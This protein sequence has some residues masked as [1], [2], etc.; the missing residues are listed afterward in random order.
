M[1]IRTWVLSLFPAKGSEESKQ[2]LASS[3]H[4]LE[5]RAAGAKMG[6]VVPRLALSLGAPTIIKMWPLV[7]LGGLPQIP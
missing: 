1:L 3:L 7:G 2:A 6:S 4:K 5:A